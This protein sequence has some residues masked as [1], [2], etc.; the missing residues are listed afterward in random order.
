MQALNPTSALASFTTNFNVNLYATYK[1]DIHKFKELRNQTET[2][3]QLDN[4]T[5]HNTKE[6]AQIQNCDN[7]I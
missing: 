4:F 1:E 6:T 2:E 7:S 3:M 5:K